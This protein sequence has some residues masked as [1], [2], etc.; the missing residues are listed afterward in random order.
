VLSR[1]I[2]LTNLW[3]NFILLL[4]GFLLAL[5]VMAQVTWFATA[6]CAIVLTRDTPL[7]IAPTASSPLE[8]RLPAGSE[9]NAKEPYGDYYRIKLPDG[10]E[11]WV[12]QSAVKKVR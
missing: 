2:G 1:P 11:G 8:A 5:S 10:T 12:L 4:F 7:R 9:V 3:R 6:N